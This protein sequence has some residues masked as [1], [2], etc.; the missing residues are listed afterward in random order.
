MKTSIIPLFPVRQDPALASINWSRDAA[1]S[2]PAVPRLPRALNVV[3]GVV[4]ARRTLRPATEEKLFKY[5]RQVTEESRIWE[6]FVFASLAA[7]ALV[8]LVLA[9]L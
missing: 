5:A 2:Q 1:L 3:D 4:I 8:V 7:C 6:G 9:L